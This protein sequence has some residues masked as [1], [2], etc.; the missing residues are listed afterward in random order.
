M[1][2]VCSVTNKTHYFATILTVYWILTVLLILVME[3]LKSAHH[4]MTTYQLSTV[5][6]PRAQLTVI[7]YLTHA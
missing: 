4:A 5:M 3:I 1:K 6:E 7:A 2:F